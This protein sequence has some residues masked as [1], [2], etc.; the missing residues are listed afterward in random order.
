MGQ[1]MT[2][3]PE[4]LAEGWIASFAQSTER[5]PYIYSY[6]KFMVIDKLS[7]FLCYFIYYI[8]SF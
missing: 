1:I 8:W 6:I 4:N 5:C 3:G 7:V 2:F